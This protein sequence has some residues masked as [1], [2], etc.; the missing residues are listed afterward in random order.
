MKQI[1]KVD[2]KEVLSESIYMCNGIEKYTS[3][4]YNDVYSLLGKAHETRDKMALQSSLKYKF[5]NIDDYEIESVTLYK[6][7]DVI[8]D[9]VRKS[10]SHGNE[11]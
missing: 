11:G 9:M 10:N 7:G 5:T 4:L 6:N 2:G 8:I 3:I 1:I